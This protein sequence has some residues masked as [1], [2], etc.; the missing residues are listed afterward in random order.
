MS[1]PS[2][3]AMPRSS[4]PV[5]AIDGPS[6]SGKSTVSRE[7]A[8]HLSLRYLDTG[9]TYRAMTWWLLQHEVDPLD[10]VAIT[11]LLQAGMGPVI[12]AVTDPQHFAVLLNGENVEPMIRNA[13]VT[14]AVSPV[15]AV[16]VVR[17]VLTA[18]QRQIMA[19]G[20]IVAEG[21][22][23]GTVVAPQADVKIFLTA[24]ARERANRRV[25]QGTVGDNVN[26]TL[27]AMAVR[28]QRDSQR[29]N[30][31]LTQA[32]DAHVIDTTSQDQHQVIET[33][34]GVVARVWGRRGSSGDQQDGSANDSLEDSSASWPRTIVIPPAR[35]EQS[36]PAVV[37]L[38]EAAQPSAPSS[39]G[40]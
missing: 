30:A 5:I 10:D 25:A 28:D 38:P 31:P 18:L 33:V 26:Q 19:G 9:A 12:Q 32:A 27:Q 21:R 36:G 13:V 11:G 24:D 4:G 17:Q 40:S 34:L 35:S 16:P 8:Q 6:G 3:T 2:S 23:V 29:R 39:A 20:G 14:E 1:L 37:Q 22:D 7:V 15:S